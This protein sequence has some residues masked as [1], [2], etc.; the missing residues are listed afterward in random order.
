MVESEEK[1]VPKVL[2]KEHTVSER[3][4]QMTETGSETASQNLN[5]ERRINA[6][7][8]DVYQCHMLL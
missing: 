8:D 3:T 4:D 1:A 6:R 7:D 2:F 5:G